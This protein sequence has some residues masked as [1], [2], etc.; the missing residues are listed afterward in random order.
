MK[1]TALKI[2]FT[3]LCVCFFLVGN[4]TAER[5]VF[6]RG[7]KGADDRGRVNIQ[8]YPWSSIGRLN[9]DGGFCTAILISS[10]QVLTAA[11]CFWNT[12]TRRWSLA[13]FF[14]FVVGYE[15][16]NYAAHAKGVSYVT[17]Y[18]SPPTKAFTDFPRSEDWAILTLDQDLDPQFRPVP[19][20]NENSVTSKLKSKR[21]A[22]VYQAGYS[23]DY[24]HVLTV[25]KN[26]QIT[27]K[28]KPSQNSDPVFVHNC[29][30]TQGDSGSPILQYQEEQVG[31][32]AIHSATV[33]FKNGNSLG[34]AVSSQQFIRF[35]TSASAN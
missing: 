6:P 28:Q 8:E 20:W 9:K 7:I 30:A 1:Q 35:V 25:H 22:V 5:Q 23:R 11:H 3:L 16:G 19:I 32:V 2:F 31:I 18:G 14:H 34:L 27:S 24:A 13:R 10:N 29:D 33:P 21:P 12:R 15:K 26:C 4:S 17:R